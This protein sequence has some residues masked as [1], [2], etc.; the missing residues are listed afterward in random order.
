MLCSVP[1]N[2]DQ[3]KKAIHNFLKVS[4]NTVFSNLNLTETF[5]SIFYPFK[6]FPSDKTIVVLNH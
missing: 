3:Q 6:P 5:L 2:I 1:V 4:E